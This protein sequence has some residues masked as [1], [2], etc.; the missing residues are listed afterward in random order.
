MALEDLTLLCQRE[1]LR[2][3][4]L[5]VAVVVLVA[6][7]SLYFFHPGPPRRIVIASGP[8]FGIYPQYAA[9]YKELLGRDGVKVDERM[10]SVYT[11]MPE[12]VLCR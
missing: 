5:F 1:R 8:E 12:S 3:G 7:A 9:R 4:V 6:W 2:I 11:P 10:T